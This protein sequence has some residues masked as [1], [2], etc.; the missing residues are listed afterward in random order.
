MLTAS[1]HKNLIAKLAAW[2]AGLALV[3]LASGTLAQ[4]MSGVERAQATLTT[5]KAAF[6]DQNYTVA[7]DRFREY[8]R[9]SP[10]GRNELA[11]AR[12]GLAVCLIE[13]P[14]KDYRA[15]AELLAYPAQTPTLKERPFAHYYLGVAQRALGEQARD[16]ATTRPLEQQSS[17]TR[18]SESAFS[19]AAIHFNTAADT[20]AEAI[21]SATDLTPEHDWFAKSRCD[22][23]DMQ[24]RI[25]RY[26]DALAA[27]TAVVDNEKLAKSR[28]R[29]LAV[30]YH[31]YASF[32]LKDFATA[33]RSLSSLA[34]FDQP[35]I[36]PHAL[37]LLART[38]HLAGD[39]PE[40]A[41]NYQA[42]VTQWEKQRREMQARSVD[43]ATKPAERE[44]LAEL[45]KKPAPDYVAR[46]LFYWGVVLSEFGSADEATLRFIRC[47][48]I[49]P[50][51]PTAAEARLRGAQ[52][53][54][55][56]RK[57]PEAAKLLGPILDH[58]RYGDQA[59]R[60]LAKAQYGIGTRPVPK[61]EGVAALMNAVPD[62][63]ALAKGI[64]DAAETLVRA[65]EKAKAI[66]ATD[67]AAK[68][69]RA[70]ILIELGDMLQL[71]QRYKE[72]AQAYAGAVG[73][74]AI[75]ETAENA[76][77]RQ[78]IALQL[79]G[80]YADS[81][82]VC[83]AFVS[84]FP[85]STMR[86]D[87]MV[88]YAENALL[89][90]YASGNP[91]SA[92]ADGSKRPYGE[93]I[94]RFNRILTRH[95]DTTAALLARYGLGTI[96]YLQGQ[97]E[98]AVTEL[99]KIPEG[100]RADDLVGV[101]F[102]LA[103]CQLRA[104]PAEAEDALSSARLAGQ[105]DQVV[106]QLNAYVQT[107]PNQPETAEALIR[108]GYASVK[109]NALLAE[110]VE[111]RRTMGE[112][113][114]AYAQ[115]IS[116]YPDHPL[117]PVA[118]LENAKLMARYS[119]ANYAV[120][121]L[122]KF[123][124]APLANTQIA[125][126]A[127]IHLADAMRVRKKPDDAVSLLTT[128]RSQHEAEMLKDAD[129]AA[130][131][132][133]LNYSLALS[134]KESARYNE[135]RELFA[136]I[137]RDFPKRPEAAEAPWR[138]AQCQTEPI[139]IELEQARKA[140]ATAYRPELISEQLDKVQD[141]AKRLRVVADALGKEAAALAAKDSE[142]EVPVR[143]NYDAAWCWRIIGEV[144]VDVARR[145]LQ[146]EAVRKVQEKLAQ[147]DPT[148][149]PARVPP[150][151]IPLSQIPLQPAE[152]LARE[153]FRSVVDS[154]AELPLID[155]AR[156]ELADLLTQRDESAKAV[157]LLK[158]ALAKDPSPDLADRLRLR[159]GQLYLAGGDTKSAVAVSSEILNAQRNAYTYY[160][161]V[162][163]VEALYQ[164]KNWA[165]VI[166]HA[167]PFLETARGAGRLYGV[168]DHAL[169]RMAD[170]QGHLKK[171]AEAK[172]TLTQWLARFPGSNLLYEAK[173]SLGWVN[174]NLGDYD[175]AVAVYVEVA[176]RHGGEMGAKA[177]YQ[178]GVCRLAQKQYADA[179]SRFL[180]VAYAYDYPELNAT[181]MYQAATAMIQLDRKPEAKKLLER[182]IREF[183]S[184]PSAAQARKQLGAL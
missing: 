167:Q 60:Y 175:G 149:P 46:A 37:Y 47:V 62:P 184:S 139:M 1:L 138:I 156:I 83:N 109:L 75:L 55:S 52:N 81:D 124:A 165:G 28:Y 128:I 67:P 117:Y 119:G 26:K 10:G 174:Q 3:G 21:K 87:V 151:E 19:I 39:R 14:A 99:S 58:P 98:Q 173:F 135:A 112:A 136:K 132:P 74:T 43:P 92:N 12:Y 66:A 68:E 110:P 38:H 137:A 27:A 105:L 125:P 154:F 104:L 94:Q 146:A 161:R 145:A 93:A 76:T 82:K 103:D 121:E 120:N 45:L 88:R 150:P 114:R 53:G 11:A 69:R 32:S 169:L 64:K 13:G 7:A 24:L 36:G 123:Q 131:V 118:M 122:S 115:V 171:W 129:R 34:P 179:A 101:S 72:S 163:A 41:A 182:T 61:G 141:A 159:L 106:S 144:E 15:A 8:L 89:S 113:R 79:A 49:A 42:V 22:Q 48:E 176:A 168:S 126:L 51:S 63:A 172:E 84:N 6:N 181:A 23:A 71:D 25:G 177:Q 157:E 140:I 57:F 160:A 143:M 95:P 30:Y 56:V 54:V 78:L 166:E 29:Q 164:E 116:Q 178:L 40:A 147:E 65:E 90:A 70:V 96:H 134:Y 133:V 148:A 20:F 86:P 80:Q 59:L 9:L 77:A 91:A 158:E 111:K 108:I 130:W 2:T 73:A 31:G 44:R 153:K 142:S 180:T 183:P 17:L 102:L 35:E 18:Q 155:D 50:D 85:R 4:P 16:Q 152:K 162:L 100:D 170:A 127:M 33:V 107:K 5:A 97:Y